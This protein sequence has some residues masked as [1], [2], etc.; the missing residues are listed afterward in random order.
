MMEAS[1]ELRAVLRGRVG[2]IEVGQV[3]FRSCQVGPGG[4]RVC[5][6]S[7]GHVGLG[8]SGV[9]QVGAGQVRLIGV[10]AVHVG[11]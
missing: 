9:R 7:L 1:G 5:Q 4:G 6:V 8:E 10:G 3:E 2:P 11:A